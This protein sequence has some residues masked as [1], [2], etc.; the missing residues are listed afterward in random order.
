MLVDQ[1]RMILKKGCLF[2]FEIQ[3]ICGVVNEEEHEENPLSPTNYKY[4]MCFYH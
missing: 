2:D 4:R 3:G 1:S